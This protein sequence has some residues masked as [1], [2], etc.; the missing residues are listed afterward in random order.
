[1][2]GKP[3]SGI[4]VVDF[5]M[6]VAGPTAGRMMGEWGADVIKV[7][8][9]TG[10]NNRP[11]GRMMGMPIDDR[12]NPHN[13]MFNANKRSLALNMKSEAGRA[14]MEKLLS[15]ANIFLTS[16]RT[17]ALG[18]M[19]LDYDAVSQRHPHLIWC[20]VT[21]FG[22]QGPQASNPGFDTVAFWARSGAMGDLPEK[23]TAPIPPLIAF[24]DLLTSETLCAGACAALYQQAKTGRGEKVMVSLYSNALWALG[25][26][27]Q[28]T[29][30][31]D[32]YP[33]SRKNAVSPMSNSYCCKDGV[34]IFMCVIDHERYYNAVMKAIEREDLIDHP[35][36]SDLSTCKLV[37][38]E[39]IRILEDGFSKWDHNEMHE[40]LTKADVAHSLIHKIKDAI[41][42][43]QA[44]ANH[45][46]YPYTMRDGSSCIGVA[47]PIKF[48]K[49]EAPEHRL[50]PL[51]GEH[52]VE[53]LRQYGYTEAEIQRLIEEH[54]VGVY[55]G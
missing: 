33:K 55:P 24:G 35:V 8:P 43:E 5:S 45:Y 1:M 36:Y 14:V 17:K 4:K 16:F 15:E 52:S 41:H 20:Q 42:D 39:F 6:Y 9:L 18:K 27:V 44:L 49:V 2:M 37:A 31:G 12:N 34:W 53:I 47:P 50:A 38:P 46:V 25:V 48:G 54:V 10:D 23:D 51:I 21:G 26:G 13:E 19:G 7:E 22:T 3:L 11:A 40:R 28:S 30:Y 32:E 29:Q